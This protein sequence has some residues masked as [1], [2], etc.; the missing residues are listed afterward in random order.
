MVERQA[1][2]FV[3]KHGDVFVPLFKRVIEIKQLGPIEE[4]SLLHC[5]LVTFVSD[6]SSHI[7]EIDKGG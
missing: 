2:E 4:L 7:E 5:F 1:F 3:H 6:V